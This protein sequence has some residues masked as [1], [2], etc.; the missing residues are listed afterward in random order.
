M[1]KRKSR[2]IVDVVTAL[3]LQKLIQ[4]L[5]GLQVLLYLLTSLPVY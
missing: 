3:L 4:K 5:I 2:G 1:R